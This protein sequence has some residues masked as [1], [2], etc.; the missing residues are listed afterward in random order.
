MGV[1]LEKIESDLL[2]LPRDVRAHL[3]E[4]L[5]S[6][7][8]EKGDVDDEWDAEADR[9]YRQYLA[10]EVK[11]IPAAQALAELRARLRK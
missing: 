6:S 2:E 7:L 9:R 11:P 5:L 10:G 3:A 8:D 1:R 4:V